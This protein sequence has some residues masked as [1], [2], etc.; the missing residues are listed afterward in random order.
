MTNEAQLASLELGALNIT[1]PMG[2]TIDSFEL[3][4]GHTKC[5]LKP[6]HLNLNE[7]A[8]F[9]A[10]VSSQ[11]IASFLELKQVGGLKGFAVTIEPE[12]LTVEATAKVVVTMRVAAKCGLKIQNNSQLVVELISVSVP[13]PMVRKMVEKELAKANPLFDIAEV[14]SGASLSIVSFKDDHIVITGKADWPQSS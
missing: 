4:V 2:L 12:S 6:F 1:L 13:G 14:I 8:D 7:P 10:R 5:Q 11:N 9:E 3:K